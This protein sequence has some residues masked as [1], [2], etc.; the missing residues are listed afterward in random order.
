MY[1]MQYIGCCIIPVIFKKRSNVLNQVACLTVLCVHSY[2]GTIPWTCTFGHVICQQNREYGYKQ[3][4][5]HY[6]Y[7]AF[8][9]RKNY[10]NIHLRCTQGEIRFTNNTLNIL[11]GLCTKIYR[12]YLLNFA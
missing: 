11:Q 3:L 1:S 4:M 10:R 6:N 7:M 8:I 2:F 12:G 9:E 5:V